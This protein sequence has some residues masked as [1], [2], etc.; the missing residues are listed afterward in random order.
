MYTLLKVCKWESSVQ[1][2]FQRLKSV[3]E[4]LFN[5]FIIFTFHITLQV[6][7]Q[8]YMKETL[9]FCGFKKNVLKMLHKFTLCTFVASLL[10]NFNN[11]NP[12]SVGPFSH[13]TW[14]VCVTCHTGLY[15]FNIL[16]VLVNFFEIILKT[17][18]IM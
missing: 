7:L 18:L 5:S 1:I 17:H 4:I 9:W 12:L 10:S 13:L 15:F 2:L 8:H 3:L 14:K 11:L 16:I 6:H